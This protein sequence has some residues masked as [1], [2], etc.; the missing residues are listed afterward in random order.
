MPGKAMAEM[1]N[2]W[3]VGYEDY[4]TRFGMK[5]EKID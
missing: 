4:E 3:S 1:L 2:R 5:S